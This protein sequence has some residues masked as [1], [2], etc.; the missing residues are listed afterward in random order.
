[1]RLLHAVRVVLLV[2][3]PNASLYLA[4]ESALCLLLLLLLEHYALHIRTLV[5]TI[6]RSRRGLRGSLAGSEIGQK[7]AMGCL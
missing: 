5:L 1:M 7:L 2:N 3:I 4:R 6:Q